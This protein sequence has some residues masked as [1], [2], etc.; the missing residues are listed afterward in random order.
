MPEDLSDSLVPNFATIQARLFHVVG[1][2]VYIGGEEV[3]D[4]LRSVLRD[5]AEYISNSRL[6][7]LLNNAIIQEA[8]N[9]ALLQSTDWNHILSAKQLYHYG[10]VFRNILFTLKKR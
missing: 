6:W 7:E 9:L 2:K 8:S 1:D 5:E 4:T 10:H 3:A